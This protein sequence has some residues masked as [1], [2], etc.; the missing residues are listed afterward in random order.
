MPYC[1]KFA[2]D[3]IE[4]SHSIYTVVLEEILHSV[5]EYTHVNC[6]SFKLKVF[7]AFK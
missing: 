4:I 5:Y 1:A 6:K 3:L 7:L 2:R